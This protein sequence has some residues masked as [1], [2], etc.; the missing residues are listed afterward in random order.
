MLFALFVFHCLSSLLLFLLIVIM[1][2]CLFVCLCYS[3]IG[4]YK[5]MIV[6]FAW[7]NYRERCVSGNS[8]DY[9]LYLDSTAALDQA[10]ALKRLMSLN[11]LVN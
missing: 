11:R 2:G 8:C 3:L 9:Y 4:I 7:I 10:N 1:F 5:C 6:L